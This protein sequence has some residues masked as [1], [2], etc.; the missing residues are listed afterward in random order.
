MKN[1]KKSQSSSQDKKKYKDD[2][3]ET[4]GFVEMQ[5]L[6]ENDNKIDRLG[7]NV[8][9]IKQLTSGITT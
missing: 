6:Q 5:T 4:K 1:N 7:K 3:E 8:K 2:D 9:A